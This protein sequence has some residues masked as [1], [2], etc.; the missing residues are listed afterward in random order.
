MKH[1]EANIEQPTSSK[2]FTAGRETVQGWTQMNTDEVGGKAGTRQGR[3]SNLVKPGQTWS[4]QFFRGGTR[5]SESNVA[6]LSLCSEARPHLCP[7]PQERRLCLRSGF[8]EW[9]RGFSNRGHASS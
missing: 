9:K 5:T 4:N 3:R 6:D 7:L 2:I 8:D 1:E